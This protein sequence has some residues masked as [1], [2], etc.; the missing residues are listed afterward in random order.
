MARANVVKLAT[1]TMAGPAI[2]IHTI[3]SRHQAGDSDSGTWFVRDMATPGDVVG[4]FNA[5]P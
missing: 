2:T 1:T 3:G 4:A 5:A